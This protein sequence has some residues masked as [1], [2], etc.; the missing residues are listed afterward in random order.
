MAEGATPW[1]TSSS[2]SNG[3][4]R[5]TQVIPRVGEGCFTSFV[6]SDDF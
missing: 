4:A 5:E 3:L 1:G 2:E 6:A